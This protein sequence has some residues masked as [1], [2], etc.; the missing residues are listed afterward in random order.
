MAVSRVRVTVAVGAILLWAVTPVL[1]CLLPCL[2]TAPA[3]QE[4]SHHRAMHCG[5]SMMTAGRTCCQVSSRPEVAT[6]ET[7]VSQSQKRGL[8]VVLVVAHVSPSDVTTRTAALACFESPPNEA[9]P[10]SSSV[11]RI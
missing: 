1:A 7:Q 9:S 3:Q 10:P 4:C 8:A 2:S 6:A 11:L 5:H